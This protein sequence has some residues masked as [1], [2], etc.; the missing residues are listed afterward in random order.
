M[1]LRYL[2]ILKA[3]LDNG[4]VEGVIKSKERRYFPIMKDELVIACEEVHPFHKKRQL[5]ILKED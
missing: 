3:E 2:K 1:T 4:I 5:K